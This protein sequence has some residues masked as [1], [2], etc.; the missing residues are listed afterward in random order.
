[1]LVYDKT[2]RIKWEEQPYPKGDN[3]EYEL[4]IPKNMQLNVFDFLSKEAHA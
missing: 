1:M 2:L 4:T 3:T